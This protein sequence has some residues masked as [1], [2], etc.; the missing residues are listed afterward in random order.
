[1]RGD[2]ILKIFSYSIPLR[3]YL[4]HWVQSF[5]AAIRSNVLCFENVMICNVVLLTK[6]ATRLSGIVFP[7][8]YS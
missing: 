5:I 3:I 7:M 8:H 1:M 6:P 2:I 4:Y